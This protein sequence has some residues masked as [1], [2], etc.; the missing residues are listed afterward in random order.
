MFSPRAGPSGE[1]LLGKSNRTSERSSIL[2]KVAE[3]YCG[4]PTSRMV[5]MPTVRPELLASADPKFNWLTLSLNDK[6]NEYTFKG[7]NSAT[8]S[9]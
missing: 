7:S 5:I 6:V 9:L 3:N 4:A 1:S 8:R 2:V